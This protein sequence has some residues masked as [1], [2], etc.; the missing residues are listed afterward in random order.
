[1]ALSC[2]ATNS[3]IDSICLNTVHKFIRHKGITA[4]RQKQWTWKVGSLRLQCQLHARYAKSLF[5][6]WFCH[7]N[8]V[9]SIL[10]RYRKGK[11]KGSSSTLGVRQEEWI[12]DECTW[13]R[14]RILAGYGISRRSAR[15]ESRE[16]GRTHSSLN[17]PNWSVT[18]CLRGR[19]IMRLSFQIFSSQRDGSAARVN[20]RALPNYSRIW[21]AFASPIA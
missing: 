7:M 21:R 2:I 13:G 5:P 1:M 9:G 4:N 16:T 11:R 19:R 20:P 3:N 6:F 15:P 12:A 17:T 8:V 18:G 10:K 14:N